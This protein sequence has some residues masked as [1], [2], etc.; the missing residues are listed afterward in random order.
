MT[1]YQD[2]ESVALV[3]SKVKNI[4]VS[5]ATGVLRVYRFPATRNN[6]IEFKLFPSKFRLFTCGKQN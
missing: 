4:C 6:Y 5:M 3:G 1:H 2:I